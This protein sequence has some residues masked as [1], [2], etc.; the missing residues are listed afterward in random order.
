[1]GRV[2]TMSFCELP[3]Y[4]ILLLFVSL[5]IIDCTQGSNLLLHSKRKK[6]ARDGESRGNVEHA[7][8]HTTDRK[9]DEKRSEEEELKVNKQHFCRC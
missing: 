5:F 9:E 4:T 3:T 8:A 6:K 7:H 1:M 2:L